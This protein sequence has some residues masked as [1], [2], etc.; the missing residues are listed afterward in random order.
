MDE[1]KY[2][3]TVRNKIS[4]GYKKAAPVSLK[5]TCMFNYIYFGNL[6]VFECFFYYIKAG[7][8][9]VYEP[10]IITIKEN[11]NIAVGDTLRLYCLV[12]SK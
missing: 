12:N 10:T 6:F 7:E 5:V 3:A 4:N 1:G 2:I 9:I 11:D 8:N